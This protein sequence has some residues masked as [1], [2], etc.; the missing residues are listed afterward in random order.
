MSPNDL[1]VSSYR[2]GRQFVHRM[3]DDLNPEEFQHQP[4][5]GTNSAAW[6]V[7]H[8]ALTARRTAERLGVTDLPEITEDFVSRFSVTRKPAEAQ[9][10]LGEK[11]TLLKLFDECVEKVM[12]AIPKLP[13]ES[14]M[15]PLPT[16]SPFANNSGEQLL[17]GAMHFMFHCGQIS[18]IRRSL[19]KPPLV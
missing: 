15:N 4:V 6:I 12:A 13:V 11:T 7:G 9:A 16:P 2:I 1:I 17:F 10:D 3:V 8:L 18:T 19:G 5:P 14:L